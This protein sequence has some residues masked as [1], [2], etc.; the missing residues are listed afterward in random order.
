MSSILCCHQNKQDY[1]SD[2]HNI[3]CSWNASHIQIIIVYL[4]TLKWQFIPHHTWWLFF[5]VI[6]LNNWIQI[7]SLSLIGC[8]HLV[9]S[10]CQLLW[11]QWAH[12]DLLH[13]HYID[14]GLNWYYFYQFNSKHRLKVF[15]VWFLINEET[16]VHSIIFHAPIEIMTATND[17]KF[18]QGRLTF[19]ALYKCQQSHSKSQWYITEVMG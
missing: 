4:I 2:H 5:K 7:S 9:T 16:I 18:R 8:C 19:L 3:L 14:I 13:S 1:R 12:Y 11:T 17:C 10:L 6:W 15:F